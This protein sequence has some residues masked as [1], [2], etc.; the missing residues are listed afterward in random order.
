MRKIKNYKKYA[1]FCLLT[2]AIVIAISGTTSAANVN[3]WGSTS[4]SNHNI[5]TVISGNVVKCSNSQPFSG[6]NIT[7]TNNKKV[8]AKTK[9]NINGYYSVT[10]KS[11][12]S[13]FDVIASYPGH[14]SVTKTI[15]TTT[16]NGKK[17]GTAN[18]KLGPRNATCNGLKSGYYNTI[19]IHDYY[20][21]YYQAGTITVTID[22]KSYDAYCIDLFTDIYSGDILLVNGA[23]V[24][25]G[26]GNLSSKVDWSKVNYIL[27]KFN[28]NSTING[29]KD[30]AINGAA[31]QAAIWY[32]TTAQYGKYSSTNNKKYQFMTDPTSGSWY[33]SYDAELQWSWS[34][35][36]TSAVRNLAQYIINQANSTTFN[37]PTKITVQPQS[38]ILHN[39]DTETITATVYDQNNKALSGINVSFSTDNGTLSSTSGTT[40]SLGQVTVNLTANGLN[41]GIANILTWVTGNYGTLL[42][43]DPT[44][45]P[46]QDLTTTTTVPYSIEDSATVTFAKKA[47]VTITKTASNSTPHVGQQFYYT[48]NLTNNGPDT[49]TNV[50]VTDILPS[51]L[52][53]NS[54]TATLGK[55]SN[56]TWTVGT[57]AK[58]ATLILYVTPTMQAA[59][60]TITNTATETQ[61]EYNSKTN[62]AQVTVQIPKAVILSETAFYANSCNSIIWRIFIENTTNE[63]IYNITVNDLITAESGTYW[64]DYVSYDG[65]HHWGEDGY[66][67]VT[68][69][70][71]VAE[72]PAGS[73]YVLALYSEPSNGKGTYNNSATYN[74]QKTN[75]SINIP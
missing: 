65:G 20:N 16:K 45:T 55:Y 42:Y 75:V 25:N 60:Q 7:V 3:K 31:I 24:A 18:F 63:S 73:T 53:F 47:D 5:N 49:P 37:Y 8:V 66:D 19:Y 64:T 67:P 38:S 41:N 56:G 57:L 39:G 4:I 33:Y 43:Y 58:T 17:I 27:N 54:Y 13:T 59:G 68:G 34:Q 14:K 2:F 51:G 29:S 50:N 36:D 35:T 1:I 22:G 72:L 21:N 15:R 32:Y 61:T 52:T 10:F 74:D 62:T 71:T 48:I 11:S 69:N 28:A 30:K 6:V 9:T 12:K 44:K 70:W 40:N 23:L 46:L 26:T